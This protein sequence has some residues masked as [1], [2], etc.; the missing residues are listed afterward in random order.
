MKKILIIL[1]L[2][3]FNSNGQIPN[4]TGKWSGTIDNNKFSLILSLI[5]SCGPIYRVEQWDGKDSSFASFNFNQSKN[6]L[7][8]DAISFW[9]EKKVGAAHMTLY[10]NG[11]SLKGFRAGGNSENDIEYKE[12]II[13]TRKGKK[14]FFKPCFNNIANFQNSTIPCSEMKLKF[15]PDHIFQISD[16]SYINI[17][18]KDYSSNDSDKVSLFFNKEKIL[19]FQPIYSD[20]SYFLP[21]KPP[22]N[23]TITW[24]ACNQGNI[25]QNTGELI[26]HEIKDGKEIQ[27]KKISISLNKNEQTT[28]L[29]YIEK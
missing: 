23:S 4:L 26:L 10:Y 16:S 17:E 1:C 7:V 27:I 15:I 9:K 29:I 22:G 25:G 13:L 11:N 21:F 3:Y 20:I 2:F 18:L 6:I 12:K 14:K 8:R 24:C 28:I 19:D 5:D